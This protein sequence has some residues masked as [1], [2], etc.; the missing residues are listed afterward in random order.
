VTAVTFGNHCQHDVTHN[1]TGTECVSQCDFHIPFQQYRQGI[2]IV[3]R[4]LDTKGLKAVHQQRLKE[5]H[6]ELEMID[7][8]IKSDK[9]ILVEDASIIS[10]ISWISILS[11]T[12]AGLTMAGI[13]AGL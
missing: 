11:V 13:G 1:Q 6:A 3:E 9:K 4:N 12:I 2:A 7:A 5:L 8:K 10:N